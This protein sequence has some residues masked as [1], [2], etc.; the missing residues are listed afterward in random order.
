MAESLVEL[1]NIF[2]LHAVEKRI[3]FASLQDS[4]RDSSVVQPIFFFKF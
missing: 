3:I 4:N 2:A 1:Q